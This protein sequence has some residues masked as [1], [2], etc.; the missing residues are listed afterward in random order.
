MSFLICVIINSI[1][2]IGENESVEAWKKKD[3]F[4]KGL[5]GLSVEK[6]LV[7]YDVTLT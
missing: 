5:D 1:G 4:F 2:F 7:F 3:H 6:A